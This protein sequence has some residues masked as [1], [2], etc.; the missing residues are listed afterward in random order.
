M[1]ES[2]DEVTQRLMCD[3][4]PAAVAAVLANTSSDWLDVMSAGLAPE[5]DPREVGQRGAH[6]GE[7]Q[8]RAPH[9]REDDQASGAGVSGRCPGAVVLAPV[10]GRAVRACGH[11]RTA[12]IATYRACGA[13]EGW[14][15]AAFTV[16]ST[17][18]RSERA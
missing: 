16:R 11:R 14:P 3:V 1:R 5:R 17:W 2:W 13:G 18:S 10:R 15:E 9:E 6:G 4:S 7:R 8:E 12:V